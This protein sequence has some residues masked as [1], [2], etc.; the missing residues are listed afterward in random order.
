MLIFLKC[1]LSK[2]FLS[3]KTL[4]FQWVKIRVLLGLQVS[5]LPYKFV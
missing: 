2:C 4:N 3:V 5:G 1:F